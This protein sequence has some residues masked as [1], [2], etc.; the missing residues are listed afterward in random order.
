MK[1]ISEAVLNPVAYQHTEVNEKRKFS[2][3]LMKDR[4]KKAYGMG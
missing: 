4:A 3:R 2:V 1:P